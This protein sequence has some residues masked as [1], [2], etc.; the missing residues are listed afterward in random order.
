MNDDQTY[1]IVSA[2]LQELRAVPE[3]ALC[4]DILQKLERKMRLDW[5]GQ[6]VYVKKVSVNVVER[7]RAIKARYNMTNR[8]ELQAEF[9]ISRGQFYKDL[10]AAERLPDEAGPASSLQFP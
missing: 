6:A 8:R 3:L 5:G 7:R 2:L 10:R 1:D 9:G 4:D